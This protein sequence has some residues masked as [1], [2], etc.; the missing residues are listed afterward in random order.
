MQL[1]GAI[2][3]LV[4]VLALLVCAPLPTFVRL[5]EAACSGQPLGAIS[6]AQ[7]EKVQISSGQCVGGIT[8]AHDNIHVSFEEG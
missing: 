4:V 1:T 3:P 6:P 7:G 2:S 5:A 8:I